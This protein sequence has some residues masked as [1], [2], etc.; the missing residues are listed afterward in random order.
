MDTN[1]EYYVDAWYTKMNWE[2]LPKSKIALLMT[3]MLI[4]AGFGGLALSPLPDYL[5]RKRTLIIVG[6]LHFLV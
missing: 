3:F 1:Y 4:G 2:C 6:S 5:G